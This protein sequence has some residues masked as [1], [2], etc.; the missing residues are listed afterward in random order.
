MISDVLYNVSTTRKSSGEELM[1]RGGMLMKRG[2]MLMK[3]GVRSLYL[4]YGVKTIS[5]IKRYA[6]NMCCILERK[7]EAYKGEGRG[8]EE[9][10]VGSCVKY[11][12]IIG[13]QY[14]YLKYIKYRILCP[15][16]GCSIL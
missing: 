5:I 2:G 1:K 14:S 12:Y 8:S 13:R 10:R 15:Y 4:K 11:G 9:K 7:L 6:L 3:R 16:D